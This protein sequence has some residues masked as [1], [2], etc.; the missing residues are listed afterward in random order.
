MARVRGVSVMRTPMEKAVVTVATVVAVC[1]GQEVG[2]CYDIV[3]VCFQQW[4]RIVNL[5]YHS[6]IDFSSG[7]IYKLKYV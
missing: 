3:I 1:E 6:A 2:R 7:S 5:T 4:V